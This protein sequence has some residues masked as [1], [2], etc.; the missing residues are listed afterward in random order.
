MTPWHIISILLKTSER[1]E[2]LKA[3]R[4]KIYLYTEGKYKNNGSFY[5]RTMQAKKRQKQCTE[6]EKNPVNLEFITSE[7]SSVMQKLKTFITTKP[8]L[9]KA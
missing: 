6:R 8:V 9:Q 3:E 7:T 2:I 5:V 1:E 4:E